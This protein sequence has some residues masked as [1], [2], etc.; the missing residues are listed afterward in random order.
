M[1]ARKLETRFLERGKNERAAKYTAEIKQLE[2]ELGITAGL[3][4]V[5]TQTTAKAEPRDNA[6]RRAPL[7]QRPSTAPTTAEENVVLPNSYEL[8]MLEIQRQ[9]DILDREN[10]EKAARELAEKRIKEIAEWN[11]Q[12]NARNALVAA[13]MAEEMAN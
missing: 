9:A 2:E 1:V 11:A 7:R 4:A 6:N 8:M 3:E 10:A 12:Q 5:A 13:G